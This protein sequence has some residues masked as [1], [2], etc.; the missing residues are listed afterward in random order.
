MKTMI[1]I[2]FTEIYDRH[3]QIYTIDKRDSRRQAAINEDLG[4]S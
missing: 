1:I 4:S 2:S 3:I